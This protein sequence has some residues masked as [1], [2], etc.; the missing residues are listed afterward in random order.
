MEQAGGGVYTEVGVGVVEYVVGYAGGLAG[1][2]CGSCLASFCL[3][4]LLHG[5]HGP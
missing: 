1:I 5:P 2:E 3:V 4:V